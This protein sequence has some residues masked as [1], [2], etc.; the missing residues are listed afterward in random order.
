MY[1]YGHDEDRKFEKKKDFITLDSVD[2]LVLEE[3]PD[4]LDYLYFHNV[5]GKRQTPNQA[6]CSSSVMGSNGNSVSMSSIDVALGNSVNIV[7]R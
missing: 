7:F 6:A 2:S 5:I 3:A 1:W 4:F